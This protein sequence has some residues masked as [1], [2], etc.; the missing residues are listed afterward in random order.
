M[1]DS[2]A[3]KSAPSSPTALTSTPDRLHH[4]GDEDAAEGE[5]AKVSRFRF[6][7]DL[8][9]IVA[10]LYWMNRPK[11]RN[12]QSVAPPTTGKLALFE[13][14]GLH[15]DAAITED[16]IVDGNFSVANINLQDCRGA[17]ES[18]INRLLYIKDTPDA[19]A[20]GKDVKED[21][22][23]KG[24]KASGALVKV[25]MDVDAEG[26]QNVDVAVAS[27]EVVVILDFFLEVGEFFTVR[28]L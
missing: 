2:G 21:D 20:E 13:V 15:V 9:S 4:H 19:T 27:F 25:R 11:S 24:K 12:R 26:N 5:K 17:F 23:E 16:Y 8:D 7:F 1:I 22:T 3:E 10:S 28:S 6:A 18:R 14:T